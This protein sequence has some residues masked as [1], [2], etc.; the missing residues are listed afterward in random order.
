MRR[1]GN[2]DSLLVLPEENLYVVADGMGGHEAGEV[3]SRLAVEAIE[4]YFTKTR[5]DKEATWPHVPGKLPDRNARR[6]VGALQYAH[7]IIIE[8][9]RSRKNRPVM[10]TTAVAVYF[11]DSHAY[12]AHVGD[13]RCYSFY[14]ETLQQITQDHTL[15]N[16]LRRRYQLNS[17]EREKLVAYQ[18]IVARALGGDES[19]D[20]KVD[21]NIH[22]PRPGERFLLCSDGLNGE[23]TDAEIMRVLERVHQPDKVCGQLIDLANRRGGRDNI[24]VVMADFVEGDPAPDFPLGEEETVEAD[25]DDAVLSR[26]REQIRTDRED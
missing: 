2:E 19:Q 1:E 23:V 8:E 3:A 13:S 9:I 5:G 7:A 21:I 15:A 12:V 22:L 4:D 20:L 14:K 26:I 24:T 11:A 17:K 10:G 25:L 16:D 6:L 18:H